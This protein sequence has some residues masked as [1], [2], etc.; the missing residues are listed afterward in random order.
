MFNY[1]SVLSESSEFIIDLR[2]NTGGSISELIDVM[3][4]FYTNDS[5]IYS[6]IKN[7][8]VKSY[9]TSKTKIIDFDKIVFL[10][11][12]HTASAAEIM[13]FNMKSDFTDKVTTVGSKTY[14]KNFGYAYKQF[15]DGELFM[16]VSELMGNSK[17]ETFEDTGIIPDYTL[18][19]SND[20]L[21][22]AVNIINENGVKE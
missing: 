19:E 9:K 20:P 21:N 17:G 3:S 7:D 2:G 1:K 6:E 8:E 4:L 15:N 11:D 18:D 5:V 12:E 14:G 22:F 10:C 16:F 13:I